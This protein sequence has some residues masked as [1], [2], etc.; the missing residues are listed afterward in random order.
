MMLKSAIIFGEDALC[1]VLG[2]ALFRQLGQSA[3]VLPPASGA[4][5]FKAGIPRMNDVAKSGFIVLMLADA[6]QAACAPV[7]LKSWAPRGVHQNLLL[8]L[9]V[10]ESESWVLADRM[11]FAEFVQVSAAVMPQAPDQL[12]DPKQVLLNLVRRGKRRDL[13]DDMLP[14]KG[15]RSK[16]GLGYNA[17]LQRFVNEHW[18]SDRAMEHSPSLAKAVV[19][20]RIAIEQQP[21]P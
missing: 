11:A 21:A 13:R 4:G 10:R 16:I 6:D 1:C 3:R 14:A 7:Q 19:R 12:P 8:R 20:I 17:Q 9:A 15:S 18:Q 2:N 5:P